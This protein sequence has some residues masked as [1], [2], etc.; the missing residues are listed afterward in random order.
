MRKN[1]LPELKAKR[2]Y[3]PLPRPIDMHLR[4]GWME[5]KG[6]AAYRKANKVIGE[7]VA[8]KRRNEDGEESCIDGKGGL[9]EPREVCKRQ[10]SNAGRLHGADISL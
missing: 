2:G 10:A 9:E 7:R 6:N 5:P 8:W 4:R 3:P 1:R